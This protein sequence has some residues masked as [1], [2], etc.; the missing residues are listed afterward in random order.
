MFFF[1]DRKP[2]SE[3]IWTEKL[4]IYDLRTNI[5]FTLKTN[6]LRFDDLRDFISCY[7]AKNRFHRKETERFLSFTYAELLQRD[8]VILDIFWFKDESLEDSEDLPDPEVLA[9]D[10]MENFESALE[11]FSS[12]YTELEGK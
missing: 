5:H 6:T 9:R 1:F 8:K 12:I 7:H 4:W 11:Q 2:A 10:I 3:K